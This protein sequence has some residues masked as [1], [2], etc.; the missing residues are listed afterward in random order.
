MSLK[1]HGAFAAV[2]IGEQFLFIP[3]D[4]KVQRHI[5]YIGVGKM[6]QVTFNVAV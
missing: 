2:L 5:K 3:F 1:M 4:A 6:L